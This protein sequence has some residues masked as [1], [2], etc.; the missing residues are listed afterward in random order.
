M[1]NF[2]RT[3]RSN[4]FK[5]KW[6]NL[7]LIEILLSC[8]K[9]IFFL[10]DLPIILIKNKAVF[11]YSYLMQLFVLVCNKAHLWYLKHLVSNHI[12]DLTSLV[13]ILFLI[14]CFRVAHLLLSDIVL[15]KEEN[16]NTY[17]YIKV[18]ITELLK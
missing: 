1:N 6:I 8:K 5:S 2:S 14:Q 9:L 15:L 12:R 11:H 7:F 4:H 10:V 13:R 3:I 17:I 16:L 18:R